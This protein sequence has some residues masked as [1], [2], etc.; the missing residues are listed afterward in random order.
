MEIAKSTILNHI[1]QILDTKLQYLE[2]RFKDLSDDLG[3]SHKSSAGDKHETARAMTQLE[4]EKLS[5]QLIQINQ[6]KET[7]SK[8]KALEKTVSI[9][10][11]N[12]IKT[13]NGYF[14]VSIGIGK[15][16]VGNQPVYCISISSP[17]AQLFLGRKLGDT[18]QFNGNNFIIEKIN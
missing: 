7:I 9:G 5:S 13:N 18:I 3:S 1:D 16:D 14:F 12:L 17:V 11:G 4:Q 2:E 15:I 10:F 6:Q 8:I